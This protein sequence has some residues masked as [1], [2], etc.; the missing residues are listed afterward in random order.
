MS[1]SS[2]GV[3]ADADVA[4]L[5]SE[6]SP[7]AAVSSDSRF[8]YGWAMLPLA[9]MALIATAPGQTFGVSAFNDS[10][11]TA[12]GLSHSQLT[13]AYMVGT[14][15]AAIPMGY[16]GALMD[17]H[18]L[19]VTITAVVI[20]FGGVCLY[21]SQVN[22]LPG[23]FFAFLFLR[24]LGAGALGL[25]SGNALAFWFERRLGTVEGLRHM[26]MAGAIAVVPALNLWLID[27]VGWRWA[28]AI[29]GLSVWAVMLPAL[30]WFWRD[31]PEQ[32]GQYKDGLP[33]GSADG[34]VVES[35]EDEARTSLTL[36]EAMASRAYWV[37]IVCIGMWSM[38]GTALF[39]NALPLFTA[40]GLG[41][42]DVAWLFTVFAVSLA[43]MH[44]IGGL[45]ADRMPLN[46]LLASAMAALAGAMAMAWRLESAAWVYPLG[47][48][49]GLAQGLIVSTIS[50]VWPRFFGRAYM[51]RIRG[52]SATVAVA[53]SSFGPFL[54][55]AGYD[56]L[57]SYD[58]VMLLFTLLPLPMVGL[59]LIATTPAKRRQRLQ[60]LVA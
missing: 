51:G 47:M 22:S 23:L 25:L 29:L 31:R 55:G 46:L 56:L 7:G 4:N 26:G 13:G 34:T 16:V 33:H 20:L 48:L 15:L 19:R 54:M 35:A 42:A 52:T 28:Y 36:R 24:M 14:L 38:L 5:S 17:R 43:V 8:F 21:T 1:S 27:A 57:G 60:R 40:R 12:L 32:V 45:L 58:T 30:A 2:S 6:L 49:I 18:G 37:I 41:T 59:A 44:V 9:T 50:P 53:A 39:F 3:R 10:F 11:R